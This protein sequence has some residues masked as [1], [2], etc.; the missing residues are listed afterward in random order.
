MS[1]ETPSQDCPQCGRF[2]QDRPNYGLHCPCGWKKLRGRGIGLPSPRTLKEQVAER[3]PF[4]HPDPDIFHAN[5][6]ERLFSRHPGPPI[7]VTSGAYGLEPNDRI[8]FRRKV[9]TVVD[10]ERWDDD[11]GHT[12]RLRDDDGQEFSG[13]IPWTWW[14]RPQGDRMEVLTSS[15]HP[16]CGDCGEP[17]TCSDVDEGFEAKRAVERL[18]SAV[19]RETEYPVECPADPPCGQRF[20][21]ERGAAQHIRRSRRHRVASGGRLT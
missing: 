16:V 18:L 14:S 17:W 19:K 12:L 6:R 1:A 8:A 15:H 5:V 9:W 13:D 7:S 10:V 20:K 11:A 3:T 4:H 2:V 21:T